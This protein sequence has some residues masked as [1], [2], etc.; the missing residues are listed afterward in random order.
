MEKKMINFEEVIYSS[1]QK[2]IISGM[3]GFHVRTHS[4]NIDTALIDTLSKDGFFGYELPSDRMVSMEQLQDNPKIVYEYP[5][6]FVYKKICLENGKQKYVISRTVYIGIDYGY[7]CNGEHKRT[8]SNFFTHILIFDEQPPIEIFKIIV[9]NN[10]FNNNAFLPLDYTCSPDNRELT[11]LLTG[12]P[13]LMPPNCFDISSYSTGNFNLREELGLVTAG[14]LQ[15]YINRKN[16]TENGNQLIIKANKVITKEIINFIKN[17][18]PQAISSQLT[19]ISNYVREGMPD[20]FDIVF[21]NEFYNGTLYE[22]QHICIDLLNRNHTGVEKNLLLE[23]ITNLAKEGDEKTLNSLLDYISGINIQ[24]DSD[25]EFLYQIFILTKSDK[26]ISLTDLSPDFIEKLSKA[27]LSGSNK[28]M[29]WNKINIVINSG[30]ISKNGQDIIKTLSLLDIIKRYGLDKE[31][32]IASS[33]KEYFTRVLFDT[34]ENFGRIV[35]SS[36]INTVLPIIT[37]TLIQTSDRLFSSLLNSDSKEVWKAFI[38]ICFSGNDKLATNS[39]LIISKIAGSTMP[40]ET[41]KELML[42]LYPVSGNGEQIFFNYFMANPA[43]INKYQ[44]ILNQICKKNPTE[45]YP[46]L[47]SEAQDNPTVFKLITS[48]LQ[49]LFKEKLDHKENI[50]SVLDTFLTI[51]NNTPKNVFAKIDFNSLLRIFADTML[52]NP[53]EKY[54]NQID[55]LLESELKI[56]QDTL[57]V[58]KAMQ[59]ILKNESMGEN[60]MK[61][62]SF[63]YKLS[64]KDIIG[65]IFDSWMKQGLIKGDLIDFINSNNGLRSTPQFIAYMITSIWNSTVNNI[66][67]NRKDLVEAII[68][69]AK[70]SKDDFN[71][72]I[73]SDK[74][75]DLTAFI[76]KSNGFFNKLLRKLFNK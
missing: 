74:P 2:S 72:F 39:D 42:E 62:M 51:A 55:G 35:K 25:Y 32:N 8:G 22:E 12:E 67:T 54:K 56:K 34:N 28:Q 76:T 33:G 70:W 26:A 16:R 57:S 49:Q 60:N 4:A 19:F 46:K 69:N 10:A 45:Y 17:F 3:S 21:V 43:V 38:S 75:E 52:D 44:D 63:A 24:H 1:S 29:I 66:N 47:L 14:V 23:K 9:K 11:R 50:S 73:K 37:P 48:N 64:K 53:A 15:L 40:L 58:F 31:I 68:D 5:E 59:S 36:N 20:N 65:E 71:K 27:N 18:I 13:L 41:Q 30:V 7:F 61:T 6:S